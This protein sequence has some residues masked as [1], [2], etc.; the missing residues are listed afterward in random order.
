MDVEDIELLKKFILTRLTSRDKIFYTKRDDNGKHHLYREKG[1]LYYKIEKIE[2]GLVKYEEQVIKASNK[3]ILE[4]F[5]I[6]NQ[7]V[8]I[9][10]IEELEKNIKNLLKNPLL[11][12][13]SFKELQNM[14]KIYETSQGSKK[15]SLYYN[16][17]TDELLYKIG[18]SDIIPLPIVFTPIDTIYTLETLY[19]CNNLLTKMIFDR[20]RDI[21]DRTPPANVNSRGLSRG[22]SGGKRIAPA[23]PTAPTAPAYKLNGE[24]V[25]LLINKKKL[26][27]SVYV[28]GNGK[29]KYCKIN[30]EFVLLSK[31]K[32]KIL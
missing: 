20:T 12:T 15:I 16:T 21:F 19:E 2:N 14:K 26:H 8:I 9:E 1:H 17:R 22:L 18:S 10:K 11:I 13:H 30:Y 3:D 24:K 6:E 32:N 27:R 28:K 31:L 23:A 25:S 4:D 7:K 5:V 29:A